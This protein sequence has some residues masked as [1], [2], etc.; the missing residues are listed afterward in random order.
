MGYR[1][2]Q[3]IHNRGIMKGENHLVLREIQIETTLRFDLI[4]I[5]MVKIK[6]SGESTFWQE[7]GERNTPPLLLGFQ[8]STAT[9]EINLE[10]PQKIGNSST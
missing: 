8:T 9:L 4:S 5:R 1:P 7:C 3:R 6:N 10:V 2:K